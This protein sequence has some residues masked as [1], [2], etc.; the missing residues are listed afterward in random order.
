MRM[1]NNSM[2]FNSYLSKDVDW[3]D[4]CIFQQAAS[5]LETVLKVK[6]LQALQMVIWF[7]WSTIKMVENVLFSL[8]STQEVA[9]Q[10]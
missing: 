1:A 7:V 3:I 6:K 5:N 8:V 2:F 4:D 9:Q 10:I